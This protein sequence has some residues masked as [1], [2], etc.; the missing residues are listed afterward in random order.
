MIEFDCAT[1]AVSALFVKNRIN[2]S[3][4]FLTEQVQRK[5]TKKKIDETIHEENFEES[6][7]NTKRSSNVSA[8]QKALLENIA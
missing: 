5:G 6:A 2:N 3:T 7:H 8:H 4:G 1:Q